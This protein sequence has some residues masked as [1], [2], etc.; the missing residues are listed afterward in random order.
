MNEEFRVRVVL[1][2]IQNPGSNEA[3]CFEKASSLSL[4]TTDF[5]YATNI[6]LAAGTAAYN[7]AHPQEEPWWAH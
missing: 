1:D 3:S 2:I 6:F 5:Q 4:I 7:L